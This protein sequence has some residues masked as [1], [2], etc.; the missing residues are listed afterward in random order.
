MIYFPHSLRSQ[1]CHAVCVAVAGK[2]TLLGELLS[3]FQAFIFFYTLMC[4]GVFVEVTLMDKFFSTFQTL[5][6]F[7]TSVCKSVT[8]EVTLLDEFFP[9]L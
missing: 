9:A 5:I 1:Y 7:Y 6:V 8:G 4:Q 2:V 3:T